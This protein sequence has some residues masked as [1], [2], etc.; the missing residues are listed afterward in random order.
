MEYRSHL[1]DGTKAQICI[2]LLAEA[3]TDVRVTLVIYLDTYEFIM[4]R[5][6]QTSEELEECG[7][8]VT[9][10]EL[11]ESWHE[12]TNVIGTY[13]DET[14]ERS[15]FISQEC[16]VWQN[17]DCLSRDWYAGVEKHTSQFGPGPERHKTSALAN[18]GG[19]AI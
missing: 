14:A 12:Q 4:S 17:C 9:S 8:N 5:R 11:R 13:D 2:R 16:L 1:A 19:S 7:L 3:Q 18:L 6:E 15:E 10:F